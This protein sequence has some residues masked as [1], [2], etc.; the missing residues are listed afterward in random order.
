[1]EQKSKNKYLTVLLAAYNGSAYIAE[2]LESIIS[3]M[4]QYTTNYKIIVSDDYS[5]DD[6]V[7]IINNINTLFSVD[8]LSPPNRCGSAHL[9][10]SYLLNK[11]YEIDASD[12]YMLS[13]QDDI[14]TDMKVSLLMTK[15]HELEKI[16][17][18]EIP[19]LVF[20]DATIVDQNLNIIFDSFWEYESLSP[21]FGKNFKKLCLHNVVQGATMLFNKA[22]LECSAPIPIKA[23]MHDR[24]IAT[25][26]S[27][28][29]VIEHMPDKTILYRQHNS[30]L[31]GAKGFRLLSILINF[32]SY[33]VKAKKSIEA[34]KEQAHIFLNIYNSR[35]SD[36]DRTFLEELIMIGE[37]NWIYRKIFVFRHKLFLGSIKRTLGLILAI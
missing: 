37:R 21:K 12:Y 33:S 10:F 6:T 23:T 28:F 19:L 34:S 27:S 2:Q 15:M 1:M 31:V 5:T 9:N 7:N 26:A 8:I 35:I 29:G 18:K 14:W 17:G 24:W 32:M 20:S 11:A 3:S 25:V 4:S 22:L 13:D 30:N 16:H 36:S